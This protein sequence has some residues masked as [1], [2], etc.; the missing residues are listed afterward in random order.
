MH[1]VNLLSN[2][3]NSENEKG[4][5]LII[6][7]NKRFIPTLFSANQDYNHSTYI[8]YENTNEGQSGK[9]IFQD[10]IVMNFQKL[11]KRHKWMKNQNHEKRIIKSNLTQATYKGT[12]NRMIAVFPMEA[13]KARRL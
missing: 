8:P 5:L 4:T 10:I 1:R 11:T 3:Y 13:M 12:P 6:G 9:E 7:E 2:P